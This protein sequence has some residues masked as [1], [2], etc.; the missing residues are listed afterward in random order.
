M[1]SVFPPFSPRR[2]RFLR[3]GAG[4]LGTGLLPLPLRALAAS[5][6]EVRRLHPAPAAWRLGGDAHP[7][8]DVW[9]YEGTV[10]GPVLRVRQG[11]RLRVRVDN[12][13]DEPTSVHWHGLRLPNAMDGVPGVTQAPIAPGAAFDYAFHAVD[14]GTFWYH[15]HIRSEQQVGRGLY[16]ALIVEERE[17]PAVDGEW[18]WVLD[19]WRITREGQLAAFGNWHDRSHG[20]RVG[21]W[22]TVNGTPPAEHALHRGERV[23]LRLVNAAN[24]RIFGLRFGGHRPW[25]MAL[26]GHPVPPRRLDADEPMVLGPG[27]RADLFLDGE[28]H[29]PGS[30]HEVFDA[31]AR[32]ATAPVARLRYAAPRREAAPGEPAPLPAN[33]VPE[34]DLARAERHEIT[35]DGGAMGNIDALTIDG[36]PAGMRL[37]RETGLMWGING[38]AA[39]GHHLPPALT[40]ARGAHVRLR[41]R[42]NTAWPH[43]MHLHGHAFRVLTRND[44][45]VPDRP[46]QDTVLLD[47]RET[48]EVAFVADNPGDWM[49]HCHILEHQAAGMMT[50][51]RV[52]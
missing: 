5:P 14:A 33:P 42:N 3:A 36:R 22:T 13:L 38:V 31:F 45:P 50:L 15:P 11:E 47:R 19:D 1:D 6:G 27:M 52:A 8:V 9:A 16:G 49:F 2:R 41:L 25:L 21:N 48:A 10:P 29:E 39:G 26:D 51:L 32:E 46:W 23:R 34:P 7:P 43:P 24:A 12:G 30:G 40:L 18:L 17:P 37:I 35:L 28:A 4:L 20:G 44:A